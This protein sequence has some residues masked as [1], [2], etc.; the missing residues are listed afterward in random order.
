MKTGTHVTGTLTNPD[1]G[2]I[3]FTGKIT[4]SFQ[5]GGRTMY[6]VTCSDDV[7]RYVPAEKLTAIE[8]NLMTHT[9]TVHAPGR[10]FKQLRIQA[11]KC[12]ASVN[13]LAR[14]NF[15]IPTDAPVT[16]RR[17]LAAMGV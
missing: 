15:T 12:C 7:T 2:T 8:R 6:A 14:Y 17:C 3:T 11:P 1:V 13:A 4:D 10:H 16:C 5:T 9:G